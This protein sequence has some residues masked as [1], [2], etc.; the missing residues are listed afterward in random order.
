MPDHRGITRR[1]MLG[2]SAAAAAGVLVPWGGR[3]PARAE[4]TAGKPWPQLAGFADPPASVAPRFRWWWPNG[5]IDPAEIAREVD[6]VADAGCGGLEVSDVHHS[7]LLDLDVQHYGWAS[8]QWLA[9]LDAALT[10]AVKRGISVDLTIGP[11]WPAAVPTITPDSPAASCELAHGVV[12]V[13][14]GSTY[15]GPVP[16]SVRTPDADVTNQTLFAVQAARTTG[17]AVKG[18]TPLDQSSLIV[19]T[20]T[21][22]NGALTWTAPA[23]GDSW[24]L[25]S[26][27]IRGSTQQPEAGPFTTPT[28]YV[29]DH[30]SAAGTQAVTDFWD[31]HIL[32]A[33]IRRLLRCREARDRGVRKTAYASKYRSD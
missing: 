13:A 24:V 10:Q 14:G 21:V 12:T 27:W 5:Q 25:L 15:S 18:V 32:T 3:N 31:Q 20:S 11:S 17:P 9:G 22:K 19:L 30:F 26:Y 29:V 16:A 33:R 2:L 4:P 7:G 1:Q 6:A 28:S 23:T 8:E